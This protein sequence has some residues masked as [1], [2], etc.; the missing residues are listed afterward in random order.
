[1]RLGV[2]STVRIVFTK[3]IAFLTNTAFTNFEK[4]VKAILTS[5]AIAQALRE[6]GVVEDE[7]STRIGQLV[8]A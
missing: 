7:L 5:D 2:L 4:Y 1:M 3:V 8:T 6:S